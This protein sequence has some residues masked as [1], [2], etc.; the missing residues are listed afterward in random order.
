MRLKHLESALSSVPVKRFPD[1]KIDLEQ[2]ATS[3]HLTAAVIL[4]A[5]GNEDI[6]PG[7]TAM[8]LGCG[9]AMLTIGCALVDTDHVT[10]VDCDSD[11]MEVARSNVMA[12]L[13]DDEDD[14]DN[15][16]GDDDDAT[17]SPPVE[18]VFAKVQHESNQEFLMETLGGG[19]GGRGRGGRGDR[20][21]GGRGRDR[22]G[23]GRS[24]PPTAAG[25]STIAPSN[26]KSNHEKE[27]SD[28]LPF[29]DDCV[30]TVLTNPPFGTKQNAGIDVTFLRAATRM[31]RRSVY[32]F[33]KS[34]TRPYLV[35]KIKEWGY[36]VEVVAQMRYDIPKMYQFHTKDSVD[37]EVDLV[38]VDCGERKKLQNQSN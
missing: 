38:R 17:S 36:D 37:V 18:F 34:S 12:M 8:D 27:Q 35:K 33:H 6:G 4:T 11:A 19:R 13:G 7:R 25:R 15:D 5:L 21:K 30:D 23:R 2:Y 22:G 14:S 24:A 10:A 29:R 1:P 9:T 26:S 32:S 3:P 31:A 20:R 28:G 16:D